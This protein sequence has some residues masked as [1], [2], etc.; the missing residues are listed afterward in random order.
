MEQPVESGRKDAARRI[1]LE[2]IEHALQDYPEL[3]TA[4]RIPTKG[5]GKS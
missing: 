4:A 5:K 3:L 2:D 1:L